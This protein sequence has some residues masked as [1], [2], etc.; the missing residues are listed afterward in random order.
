METMVN[1]VV[2]LTTEE[3]KER[4]FDYDK[5][6]DW[7]YEGE[8]PAIIDFYADWCGPCKMVAPILEEIAKDYV[9]KLMVYK[10]NTDQEHELASVF[11]I[12]SI[13]TILFVPKKGQPQ[14]SMGAIP[15][16][17]FDQA[18]EEILLNEK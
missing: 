3:F 12:S 14:A 4:V 7:K 16:Q 13:P 9:G 5:S 1:E 10:V 11:G 8:L 15:R 17:T 18:I 6:K 2:H